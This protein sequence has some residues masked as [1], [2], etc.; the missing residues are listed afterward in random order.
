MHIG[1]LSALNDP[2]H[3]LGYGVR[4][5]DDLSEVCRHVNVRRGRH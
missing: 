5:D 1:N 2:D 4:A 3:E